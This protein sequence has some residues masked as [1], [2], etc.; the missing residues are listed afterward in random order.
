VPILGEVL[1]G[2]FELLEVLGEGGMGQVFKARDRELDRAVA[3][4]VL[5]P[6]MAADPVAT[7]DMKRE[8]RLAQRLSHPCIV[9]VYDY[10]LH[11][12][13]PFIVMEFVEGELLLHHIYAQPGHRLGEPVFRRLAEPIMT[14]VEY[15]HQQGVIHR[16]L[17]PENIM[18]TP[19]GSVKLMD[20]GIAAAAQV[21]YTRVTGRTSSLSV[22][23]A[24]PEQINGAP[25]APSMDIYSLGCVFYTML[26]G[27]PPFY[28]G[29]ILHQQLTREPPPLSE[30]ASRLNVA[31]LACL[32][33]DP[34]RRLGSVAQVRAA[35]CGDRT[36]RLNRPSPETSHPVASACRTPA[37]QSTD[38]TTRRPRL[39][40]ARWLVGTGL[41]LLV[42]GLTWWLMAP[43]GSTPGN[44]KART[45]KVIETRPGGEALGWDAP[46]EASS[47]AADHAVTSPDGPTAGRPTALRRGP[48]SAEASVA[49]SHDSTASKDDLL[50]GAAR[51][52]APAPDATERGDSLPPTPGALMA[53]ADS[54]ATIPGSAPDSAA[55]PGR[56]VDP[57]P[58]PGAATINVNSVPGGVDVYLGETHVGTTDPSGHL[59]VGPLRP[60]SHLFRF[61][62][63][64]YRDASR[65]LEVAPSSRP[66][67]SI[68]M[69]PQ[70]IPAL[71]T[72]VSEETA[73]AAPRATSAT[74]SLFG[75]VKV[76]YYH[77]PTK[78]KG[79][80]VLSATHEGLVLEMFEK[81]VVA[82][83]SIHAITKRTSF[84]EGRLLRVEAADGVRE[85]RVEDLDAVVVELGRLLGSMK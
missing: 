76:F 17:K 56:T 71:A 14:A 32:V 39:G 82:W 29:E 31:V 66:A 63:P 64:A 33:K 84:S 72:G 12:R 42:T 44:A 83:R 80:A 48:V 8:V 18:V 11:E 51:K 61:A 85:C 57:Q 52:P 7:S 69:E 37:P 16:D 25:P 60:G 67:L 58:H 70:G 28:Q 53:P 19:A 13:T 49:P 23:Y 79:F 55:R 59:I 22:A 38:D 81:E 2:R 47:D 24:S 21:N 74:A 45:P 62:K 3:L 36:I 73:P 77:R 34:M 26:A 27:H 75:P 41:V 20:F 68:A 65:L 1:D 6:Q 54:P 43:R 78:T 15:A 10:R 35:L 30:V 40:L 5:L 46:G 4:K 9:A 50:T